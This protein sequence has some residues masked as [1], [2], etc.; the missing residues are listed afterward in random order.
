MCVYLWEYRT[1]GDRHWRKSVPL[2]VR[3]FASRQCHCDPLPAATPSLTLLHS[4]FPSLAVLL[5]S[6]AFTHLSIAC[7]FC[8]L[9]AFGD[10]FVAEF[11]F[12]CFIFLIV[13]NY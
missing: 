8:Y 6:S 3:H 11:S 10:W 4:L 7:L 13:H 2:S 12:I 9:R 5:H 1:K